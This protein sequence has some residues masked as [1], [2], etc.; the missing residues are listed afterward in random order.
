[1][2]KRLLLPVGLIVALL[3]PAVAFGAVVTFT[4]SFPNDSNATISF[5]VKRVNGKNKR[6]NDL[7]VRRFN[8]NCT[9]SGATRSYHKPD[10]HQ[11]PGPEQALELQRRDHAFPGHVPE[12]QQEQGRRHA[13][14]HAHGNYLRAK[15][16]I[17]T[18]VRG[19][20]TP[21]HSR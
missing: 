5:H 11:C 1:M 17:A 8:V 3:V 4:G 6:V 10:H 12:G 13:G 21:A 2:K 14:G 18:A 7:S 15:Q 16:R 20:S 19:S 9:K